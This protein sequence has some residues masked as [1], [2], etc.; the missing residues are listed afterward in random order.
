MGATPAHHYPKVEFR[1]RFGAIPFGAQTPLVLVK[2]LKTRKDN[3]PER[4]LENKR[5][6]WIQR[7]KR[8]RMSIR[9][10][11]AQQVC[12]DVIHITYTYALGEKEVPLEVQKLVKDDYVGPRRI[13]HVF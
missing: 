4:F 11:K 3:E 10:D 1:S 6:R 9:S 8:C 2:V 5:L 7:E 13:I 12:Y